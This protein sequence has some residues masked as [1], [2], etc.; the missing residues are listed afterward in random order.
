VLN[1]NTN[2]TIAEL[3]TRYETAKKE[4]E[5]SD[6]ALENQKVSYQLEARENQTK[7]YIAAIA[8]LFL[9]AVF[10]GWRYRYKQK[11]H[12]LLKE[13]NELVT[14][15]LE[16]R[17]TLLKEIHH[18]VKNN[19][20]VI[21]SL[22]NLQARFIKDETAIDAVKEGR[23]RV[24]SMAMIH[25]KLYQGD[26]LTGVSIQE[27]IENLVDSLEK[28]Y[29]ISYEKVES[30]LD[31]EPIV[32][33]ID[34]MIPLGLILNELVSN[35]Y[36]YAFPGNK[37]GSLH[38]TLKKKD[39]NLLLTVSDDGIGYDPE[40]SKKSQSFGLT[41]IQSLMEKLKADM[42]VVHQNGTAYLFTIKNFKLA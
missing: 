22:L 35:T 27:Y 31:I 15:S 2:K 28:S 25:Q 37:T 10:I 26:N 34:T 19:L 14:A 32:L 30:R 40:G 11:L 13:K 1:E 20:Q 23:N 5:I 38:I 8:A 24:K 42:E 9:L 41:L 29:G 18:R 33:D 6:L 39:Q 4:K 36:K 12:D 7:F 16:Q 3:E 17:E 21:S